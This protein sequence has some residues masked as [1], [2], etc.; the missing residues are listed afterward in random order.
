MTT[1]LT[2]LAINADD[3]DA[4]RRFYAGVLGLDFAEYL[5]LE[6]MRTEVNGLLVAL[7]SNHDIP[8]GQPSVIVR[9]VQAVVGAARD[10][11]RLPP[12]RRLFSGPD[13][14]CRGQRR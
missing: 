6:F 5:G 13:V 8:T 2:H 14:R 10:H 9:A 7:A 11:A 12:C 1:R 4:S 3:L